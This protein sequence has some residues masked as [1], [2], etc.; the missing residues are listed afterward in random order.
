M[1]SL[2]HDLLCLNCLEQLGEFDNALNGYRT[3]LSETPECHQAEF[4]YRRLLRDLRTDN[5]QKFT[6]IW[7]V[8]VVKGEQWEVDWVRQF[9]AGLSPQEVIDG[10]HKVFLD[11]AIIVDHSLT[12]EKALYY[13]EMLQR[14]HRFALIHLSDE[15]YK[16]DCSAYDYAN[17]VIRQYWSHHNVDRRNILTIPLGCKKGF[18]VPHK[19]TAGERQY[20]W[21]FIGAVNRSH[22]PAM[23]TAM[24]E[25]PGGFEHTTDS[26]NIDPTVL[27]SSIV[28]RPWLSIGEYASILSDTVFSACP[29]GMQN[30]DSFRVCESLEAGCIPI[31]ERRANFDY[32]TYLFGAHPM[33]SVEEWSQAPAI[34]AALT[35]VPSA[36]EARRIQCHD[37]W[38]NYRH[39]IVQKIANHVMTHFQGRFRQH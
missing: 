39:E 9:C 27:D 23:I 12:P 11:N 17:C 14:G 4:R 19:K 16:D 29:I 7:Q 25:V 35:S 8:E 21:S 13:F 24:R 10:E 31:V 34:I 38:C 26:G 5:S 3:V 20:S 32:F 1:T 15:V 33:I 22:R 2:E 36:L 6:L 18:S 37:W 28:Y 30:F